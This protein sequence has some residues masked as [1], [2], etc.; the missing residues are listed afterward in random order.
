MWEYRVV[1]LLVVISL[2]EPSRPNNSSCP[3]T[4]TDDTG[5]HSSEQY[6]S[7]EN[8]WIPIGHWCRETIRKWQTED[9]VNM[10]VI[11]QNTTRKAFETRRIAQ[12]SNSVKT[13]VNHRDR[14]VLDDVLY[15]NTESAP[16]GIVAPVVVAP[17]QMLPLS[18]GVK[19][20]NRM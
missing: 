9:P 12:Y 1:I 18:H 15:A 5:I 13:L 10:A 3:E 14:L 2:V 16:T 7:E 20:R 11:D 17:Y 6:F 8:K 4:R 19:T